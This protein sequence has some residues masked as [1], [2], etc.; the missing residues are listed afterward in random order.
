M[1][2]KLIANTIGSVFTQE[3]CQLLLTKDFHPSWNSLS[4][5]YATDN[6]LCEIVQVDNNEYYL[7]I[8]QAKPMLRIRRI[9]GLKLDQIIPSLMR[10]KR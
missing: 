4:F 9:D 7:E 6:K 8:Y 10:G 1:T 3:I 2:T 5:T